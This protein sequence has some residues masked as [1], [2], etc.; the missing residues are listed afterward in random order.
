VPDLV[1]RTAR[2]SLEPL[3]VRHAEPLFAVLSAPE[4]YTHLD[5]DPPTDVR[6]LGERYRRL[7]TRRSPD[8]D[9]EWLNWALRVEDSGQY[10]GYVQATV[11]RGSAEVAYVLGPRWWGQ[12]LAT[13]AVTVMCAHLAVDHGVTRLTAHVEPANRASR[14]VLERL[15]FSF[16]R[17]TEDG[18]L[19]LDRTVERPG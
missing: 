1:L 12:G 4:I 17:R 19:L 18:D 5:E 8:G 13:E 11:E 3:E 16:V 7:E 6:S 14:A 2:L 15:G 9:E 10:A